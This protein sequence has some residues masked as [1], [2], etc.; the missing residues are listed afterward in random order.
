M[1]GFTAAG[2]AHGNAKIKRALPHEKK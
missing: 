1:P 2:G